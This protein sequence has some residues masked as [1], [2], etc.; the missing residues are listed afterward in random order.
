MMKSDVKHRK[1]RK[2]KRRT[3]NKQTLKVGGTYGRE[4]RETVNDFMRRISPLIEPGRTLTQKETQRLERVIGDALTHDRGDPN[5]PLSL[6]SKAPRV[7]N[8]DDRKKSAA[9]D[10]K[11]ALPQ[12]K[13]T[14][15]SRKKLEDELMSLMTK[16]HEKQEEVAS[17][18]PIVAS[19][20]TEVL[21]GQ[22]LRHEES[23]RV[24]RERDAKA[25]ADAKKKGDKIAAAAQK[26]AEKEKVAAEK[27]AKKAE[28]DAKKVTA[29][30]DR[31]RQNVIERQDKIKARSQKDFD[32]AVDKRM[33]NA[34]KHYISNKIM[35]WEEFGRSI[36]SGNNDTP[37]YSKG[38]EYISTSVVTD[39]PYLLS[40]S[41][42]LS[43]SAPLTENRYN[44]FLKENASGLDKLK[45]WDDIAQEVRTQLEETESESAT[46]RRNVGMAWKLVSDKSVR[47]QVY[48][49]KVKDKAGNR[50]YASVDTDGDIRYYP[51][52]KDGITVPNADI[53]PDTLAKLGAESSAKN[54]VVSTQDIS[55]YNPSAPPGLPTGQS[56]GTDKDSTVVTVLPSPLLR[57]GSGAITDLVLNGTL[58]QLYPMDPFFRPNSAQCPVSILTNNTI[59]PEM[60]AKG[61]GNK[62][63]QPGGALTTL[64]F[65]NSSEFFTKRINELSGNQSLC[66][67][68]FF[69]QTNVPKNV[70]YMLMCIANNGFERPGPTTEPIVKGT[71][72]Y[73]D[74]VSL[75]WKYRLISNGRTNTLSEMEA[76]NKVSMR[77]GARPGAQSSLYDIRYIG[78]RNECNLD[79]IVSMAA[80]ANA[81]ILPIYCWTNGKTGFFD[82]QRFPDNIIAC[83]LFNQIQRKMG[84][85]G[86]IFNDSI[87][88]NIIHILPPQ[89]NNR[90]TFKEIDNV[91]LSV[92][93]LEVKIADELRQAVEEYW[94]SPAAKRTAIT[95]DWQMDGLLFQRMKLVRAILLFNSKQGEY[96]SQMM[97]LNKVPFL[98]PTAPDVTNL[99]GVRS[100][101]ADFFANIPA[102]AIE[103][104]IM[105]VYGSVSYLNASDLGQQIN[106]PGYGSGSSMM[107]WLM[108]ALT[109][110]P[111]DPNRINELIQLTKLAP[112]DSV[113]F[114]VTGLVEELDSPEVVRNFTVIVLQAVCRELFS[115]AFKPSSSGPMPQ[116]LGDMMGNITKARDLASDKR[117]AGRTFY[118]RMVGSN[119]YTPEQAAKKR[120][121]LVDMNRY[122]LGDNLRVCRN[123]NAIAGESTKTGTGLRWVQ[124]VTRTEQDNFI[125]EKPY[126]SI[127]SRQRTESQKQ[128]D[129]EKLENR[130][131]GFLGSG[132]ACIFN[133]DAENFPLSDYTNACRGKKSKCAPLTPR[134]NFAFVLANLQTAYIKMKFRATLLDKPDKQEF[135]NDL[136]NYGLRYIEKYFGNTTSKKPEWLSKSGYKNTPPGGVVG[137]KVFDPKG[138]IWVPILKPSTTGQLGNS[139]VEIKVNVDG[140]V[141]DS[142]ASE[143][144]VAD[145]REATLYGYLQYRASKDR[146]G[147]FLRL[148]D[149]DNGDIYDELR[150]ILKRVAVLTRNITDTPEFKQKQTIAEDLDKSQREKNIKKLESDGFKEAPQSDGTVM[151]IP[152]NVYATIFGDPALKNKRLTY[153]NA[154]S[155]LEPEMQSKIEAYRTDPTQQADLLTKVVSKAQKPVLVTRIE[156]IKASAKKLGDELKKASDIGEVNRIIVKLNAV[157]TSLTEG[158][159]NEDKSKTKAMTGLQNE[160]D[161]KGGDERQGIEEYMATEDKEP[162]PNKFYLDT[163]KPILKDIVKAYERREELEGKE[164]V[165]DVVE[166]EAIVNKKPFDLDAFESKMATWIDMIKEKDAYSEEKQKAEFGVKATDKATT[167]YEAARNVLEEEYNSYG[168]TVPASLESKN[169]ILKQ[170]DNLTDAFK[171]PGSAV[172][173]NA[174]L[175]RDYNASYQAAEDE[176]NKAKSVLNKHRKDVAIDADGKVSTEW[177][178]HKDAVEKQMQL[179][180]EYGELPDSLKEKFSEIQEQYKTFSSKIQAG[181][182][183]QKAMK[184]S[185][186]EKKKLEEKE[187]EEAARVER[188]KERQHEVAMKLAE[189]GA[190]VSAKPPAP[191]VVRS[192]DPASN[193]PSPPPV[194]PPGAASDGSG[195]TEQ[196]A[197]GPA[198]KGGSEIEAL[199]MQVAELQRKIQSLEGGSKNSTEIERK[200]EEFS[201]LLNMAGGAVPIDEQVDEVVSDIRNTMSD[202]DY[203]TWLD[204]IK[205]IFKKIF[206]ILE[207]QYPNE[208]PDVIDRELRGVLGLV[209][210][211]W[212]YSRILETM[213]TIVKRRLETKVAPGK[214]NTAQDRTTSVDQYLD[215]RFPDGSIENEYMARKK[216]I[217]DYFN[218][219]TCVL[220][221]GPGDPSMSLDC[222]L[223]L[224][225]TEPSPRTSPR[226]PPS[227]PPLVLPSAPTGSLARTPPGKPDN[228]LDKELEDRF[229]RLKG[230]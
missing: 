122:L 228:S 91:A 87:M 101:Y 155:Y 90:C 79:A 54:V 70:A 171:G 117:D 28:A 18:T 47:P 206:G 170:L 158:P 68:L 97:T 12:D 71:Q 95:K 163:L 92:P 40:V 180:K 104:P 7:G 120:E 156:D 9:E 108:L 133:N 212:C 139:R 33:G 111:E 30:R 118:Q 192:V 81:P 128:A 74:P 59:E 217:T 62:T 130:E 93:G 227:P 151:W 13:F 216:I 100:Y 27:K 191:A 166:A 147:I 37:N 167:V 65:L 96:S 55:M 115:R 19:D 201:S 41:N 187:K 157:K 29:A 103:N 23:L 73:W 16:D 222:V 161:K 94:S 69:Q 203:G 17:E 112:D 57:K 127:F 148:A 61:Y 149:T 197:A 129:L 52:D 188:D 38:V 76:S 182:K 72:K 83:E 116:D 49:T 123:E 63:L 15:D 211:I 8:F 109:L 84:G 143:P 165:S 226:A 179:I 218:K 190:Q 10:L 209:N 14:L 114:T 39:M 56:G 50:V 34:A 126:F 140:T 46:A 42:F 224:D 43:D 198:Q 80:G 177:Q 107:L 137:T 220:S 173:A 31:T 162:K 32:N 168:V 11:K 119:K 172:K 82:S 146:S 145:Y 78:T 213:N 164:V 169:K 67:N 21:P 102:N 121:A 193:K 208:P 132:V 195:Q 174:A 229:A 215:T 99:A 113:N 225:S 207:L 204:S 110:F 138:P 144:S 44:A 77:Q 1:T 175:Q 154:I 178:Q 134:T 48:D 186:E 183:G 4:L 25:E 196:T 185:D 184:K 136:G 199:R 45:T 124:P 89:Y 24:K 86:K 214:T 6:G 53:D 205:S 85:E 58:S 223:D 189:K 2:L 160:I 131:D 153:D 176:M 66:Y 51:V 230:R 152:P 141:D 125:Q 106:S 202:S 75:E 194:Q 181:E 200:L 135:I 3:G 150:T 60:F 221:G 5:D 142:V 36:Q 35:D 20:G 159:D 210:A 22:L 98:V 219:P 64:D 26:K 88:N 105:P